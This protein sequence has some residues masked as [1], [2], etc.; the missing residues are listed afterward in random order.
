MTRTQSKGNRGYGD[1]VRYLSEESDDSGTSNS[2]ERG[3]HL[4]TSALILWWRGWDTWVR[5]VGWWVWSTSS[6]GNVW[7]VL[8]SWLLR[9]LWGGLLW[10]LWGGFLRILWGWLLWVGGRLGGR[11]GSSGIWIG[12]RIDISGGR[13]WSAADLRV[14]GRGWVL[15]DWVLSSG[16]VL[17]DWLNCRAWGGVWAVGLLRRAAGDGNHLGLVDNTVW[18]SSGKANKN[19]RSGNGRETHFDCLVEW[20][21]FLKEK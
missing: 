5:G 11:I 21:L 3:T 7:W 17:W 6:G 12:R 20:L 2:D 13:A 8:G 10:V 18:Q 15:G 1:E 4:G 16:W 14:L 9:I 19:G